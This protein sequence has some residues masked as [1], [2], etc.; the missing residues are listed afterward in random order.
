MDERSR[1]EAEVTRVYEKDTESEA[2]AKGTT[3]E[4]VKQ[5]QPISQTGNAA[6][7]PE[8]LHDGYH[9][10]E[11]GEYTREEPVDEEGYDPT[12]SGVRQSHRKPGEQATAPG[13]DEGTAWSERTQMGSTTDAPTQRRNPAD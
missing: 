1:Q 9:D 8:R 11:G 12:H 5:G 10:T 7:R 13:R 2:V 4:R 6:T 3:P